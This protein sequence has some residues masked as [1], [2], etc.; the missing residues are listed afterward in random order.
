MEIG[1]L[2]EINSTGFEEF[3][4]AIDKLWKKILTVFDER[5]SEAIGDTKSPVISTNQLKQQIIGWQITLLC[6]FFEDFLVQL[7][8]KICGMDI[9]CIPDIKDGKMV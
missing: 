6:H 2:Y 5:A 9:L 1:F 4:E 8:I 3:L 7:L